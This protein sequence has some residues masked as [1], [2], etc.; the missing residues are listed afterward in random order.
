MKRKTIIV[1]VLL[2]IALA[3]VIWRLSW[4]ENN[5]K[6]DLEVSLRLPIPVVDTAFSPYYLGVDKKIFAKHGLSVTLEPGTPELN[7]VK[8]LSQGTDEFAV[9]GGP[10]L[11][12][13]ARAKGAPLVA[14]A[15]IHKDSD[16]VVI[17]TPKKSGLTKVAQLEGKKVGFFYGHI[18]TD[19]L[20][21]LL[22]KENVRISEVDVGF[23]YGP[24]ISGELDAQWA[25]RTTAGIGLP[26]KGFDINV[27][28]PADYGI[29][30]QGHVVVTTEKM[31]KE[32]PEVV[33]AFLNA[34]LDAMKYS[35]DHVGEAVD[36]AIARD[37]KFKRPVGE[38][39]MEIY[40]KAIRNN[41]QLGW[42]PEDA[43][44]KTKE[45]MV[46]AG[47]VV[48]KFDVSAAYTTRFLQK[49]HG[50]K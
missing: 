3:I 47:L 29:A 34:V 20:R 23:N 36:S 18:S 17:V 5:G 48:D 11:L 26:A 10:E 6:E 7:P 8:M 21:M 9:L 42:I 25:F 16:F 4:P 40:N 13:T 1:G 37:P 31:I 19:I 46:S 22:K 28:S 43:M 50:N 24:L 30:T 15:L 49:Y 2:A 38:K 45:Q 39:Q 44:Q 32:K 41:S 14:I 27:I 33:Q 12:F 35:L